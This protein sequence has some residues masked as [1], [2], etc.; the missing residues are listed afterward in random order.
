MTEL[1]EMARQLQE[2][3]KTYTDCSGCPFYCDGCTIYG[4][5][6]EW[7]VEHEEVEAGRIDTVEVVRCKDCKYYLKSNE[8]CALIDTRLLF[9][10]T[11][12]VWCSDGFCSW[13]ERMM[14]HETD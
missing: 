11:D 14:K 3:C 2:N 5:P 7:E 9:Y 12:K 8:K 4:V 6:S 1:Q 13:A 10:E